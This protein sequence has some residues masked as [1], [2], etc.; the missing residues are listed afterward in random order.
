MFRWALAPAVILIMAFGGC[1]TSNNSTSGSGIVWVATQGDQMINTYTIDENNGAASLVGGGIASG[2]Q[3]SAMAMTPDEKTIFVA[4]LTEIRTY[5]VNGDGTLA[6]VGSPVQL[7]SSPAGLAVD[8]T[9]MYLFAVSAGNAGVLGQPGTVPGTI[10]IFSISS[11]SAPQPIPNSPFPSAVP[12]DVTG[13]GPSAIVVSPVGNYFYVANKFTNTVTSFSY[14]TTAGSISLLTAYD[15]GINPA[16]L[17]FSRC[18]GGNVL[19]SNC[20]AADNNTLFVA[21]SGASNSISIFTACIQVTPTCSIADGSLQVVSGSPI[22]AGGI[23]PSSVIVDPQLDFVYVVDQLSNQISQF[24]YS[25]A[26]GAL[27]PL[28]TATIS[29]GT[30]PVSGGITNDGNYVLVP[31]NG[32]SDVAVFQ[33]DSQVSSTGT[34]P[35]GKLSRAA[36]PFITLAA[37]PSAV[38]VR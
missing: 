13:N 25:P 27:T 2:V 14:D 5:S 38:I 17:A 1:T 35:T 33:V 21:N 12:G 16:A 19:N 28:S 29:T 20:A 26:T 32:G 37:Q 7:S 36:T 9:G 8:P 3:P 30:G 31:D 4:D 24:K 23:G 34:A 15:T 11:G 22:S 10:S 6:A 18:A